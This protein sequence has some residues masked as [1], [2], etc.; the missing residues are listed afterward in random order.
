MRCVTTISKIGTVT[1]S[2][3]VIATLT[4]LIISAV[5]E[6]RAVTSVCLLMARRVSLLILLMVLRINASLR[7]LVLAIVIIIMTGTSLVIFTLTLSLMIG[8][9]IGI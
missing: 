5:P 9:V 1:A 6:I 4:G 7:I 3:R 2:T 8:C